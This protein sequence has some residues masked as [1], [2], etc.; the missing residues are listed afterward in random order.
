VET[1]TVPLGTVLNDPS[2]FQEKEIVIEGKII[3]ECPT[4]CWFE[5]EQEGK[6]MHV[7]LGAS[8][9]AIPQKV[10]RDV[11]VAGVIKERGGKTILIGKGVNIE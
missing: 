3:L 1:A 2:V 7:E 5:L 8:G 11:K 9:F 6:T 4:G 10:G